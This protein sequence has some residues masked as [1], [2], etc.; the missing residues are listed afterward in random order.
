MIIVAKYPNGFKLSQTY[1]PYKDIYGPVK[2]DNDHAIAIEHYSNVMDWCKKSLVG[3]Y[4]L[5]VNDI[6]AHGVRVRLGHKQDQFYFQ[7]KW[8]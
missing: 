6:L 3:P 8:G 4:S 5:D 1:L 2:I 7:L